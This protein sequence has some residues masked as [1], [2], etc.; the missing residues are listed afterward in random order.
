MNILTLHHQTLIHSNK[1]LQCSLPP[2]SMEVIGHASA[3]SIGRV[4]ISCVL[5]L[6]RIQRSMYVDTY[7]LCNYR[8][9]LALD[10]LVHEQRDIQSYVLSKVSIM[11]VLYHSVVKASRVTS[12]L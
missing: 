1:L 8:S 9:R 12:I 2:E 7:L 6:T 5:L 3:S 11:K 10:T 4:D